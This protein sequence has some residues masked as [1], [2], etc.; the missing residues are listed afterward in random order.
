MTSSLVTPELIS[1][2]REL[3]DEPDDTGGYTDDVLTAKLLTYGLNL[4]V[5]AYYIWVNKAA[6]LSSLVDITESGSSRK[7][8]QAY[9]NAQA[10]AQHFQVYVPTDAVNVGRTSRVRAIERP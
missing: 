1:S 4:N 9:T 3:I 10:M 6:A 2:L 7:N 5:T 8:S